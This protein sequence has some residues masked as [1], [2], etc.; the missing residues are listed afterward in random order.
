MALN[1]YEATYRDSNGNELYTK[2]WLAPTWHIAYDW[3]FKYMEL[4]AD[5]T[6]DFVLVVK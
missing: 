5:E 1:I 2:L 3:A 4:V 6:F